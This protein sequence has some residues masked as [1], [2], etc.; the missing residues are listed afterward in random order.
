METKHPDIQ[1]K[2]KIKTNGLLPK[3]RKPTEEITKEAK[4][5]FHIDTVLNSE[6]YIYGNKY[7]FTIIDEYFR[8]C[9]VFF[10]KSKANVFPTFFNWYKKI[11]NLFSYNIKHI[12]TDIETE[13]SNE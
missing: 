9:W 6:T 3:T 8:Y 10:F 7:F 4:Q 5:T 11:N 1:W 2:I 13:Y 12:K